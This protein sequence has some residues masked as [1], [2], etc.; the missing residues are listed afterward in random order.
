VGFVV[1]L[2]LESREECWRLLDD[3]FILNETAALSAVRM[4]ARRHV[5]RGTVSNPAPL[6][7]SYYLRRGLGF[8]S[9]V[10]IIYPGDI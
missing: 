8:F 6:A 1:K 10:T 2:I 5:L 9:E 4:Y 3:G 7:P